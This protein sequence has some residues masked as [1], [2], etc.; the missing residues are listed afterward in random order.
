MTVIIEKTEVLTRL[1][2]FNAWVKTNCEGRE[3]GEA[4]TYLNRFFQCFGYDDVMGAGGTFENAQKASSKKGNTG[5]LD[6]LFPKVAII[7]MKQ[8]GT[9]LTHHYNQLLTYWTRCT[10]KPRVGILCNFDEFWIYDFNVQVDDPVQILTLDQLSQHPEALLFMLG[11]EP[12]FHQNMVDITEDASAEIS[13]LY[14]SILKRRKKHDATEEDV[15]RF[16]LQCVLCLFAEDIGL[17]PDNLFTNLLKDCLKSPANTYNVLSGLFTQMNTR[18]EATGGRFKGVKYFNGGLFETITPIE[19]E[20][21]ELNILY[22]LGYDYD[23]SKVRPS[24]F[25]TIFEKAIGHVQGSH[26]TSEIDIYKIVNPTIVQYWDERIEKAG[27]NIKKLNQ[28]LKDIRQYKVLDPAC[29]SGNFLY[30]AYQE[31]KRIEKQL[32]LLIN[33]NAKTARD[34]QQAQMSYVTPLQFYGFEIK[35]FAVELARLTLEIGRKIAV[36]KFN[37]P[38]DVLPL[39]DLKKNIVCADALF[40]EWP[41]T[42]VIIGNPPFSGRSKLRKDFGDEYVDKIFEKHGGDINKSADYC[43]YWFRLAQAHHAKRIG[44]VATNSIKQN[45][46]REASL[47]HITVNGGIIFNAISSLIWTGDAKVHHSIVN[48]TK[49]KN[50]KGKKFLDQEEVDLINPDLTTGTDVT[51]ARLLTTNNN[52]CFQGVIP[53]PLERFEVNIELANQWIVE[54]SK[55]QDILKFLVSADDL[56]DKVDFKPPKMIIDFND[57][58]IEEA[59]LYPF[60]FEYLKNNLINEEGYDSK[61][62]TYHQEKWWIH[63]RNRNKMRKAISSL[64]KYIAI[65]GTSKWSMPVFLTH[66]FLCYVNSSFVVASDDFYLL[67]MITSAFHQHWVKAQCSTLKADTRYT[68]TTCFD[69]FPFLWDTPE[70]KKDTVR[71][72]MEELEAY[73]MTE[74]KTRQWGITQLYN[75]FFNE[76]A[77][78]L[79][80]LHKK[81]DE[82]VCKVY[83]WEYDPDKN[84]NE[85]LFKLNQKLYRQEKEPLSERP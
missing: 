50:Y 80:K 20:A 61:N 8:R 32:M 84:Y 42:D 49:E 55:Y 11:E 57:R 3:R 73:R 36:N 10:P 37:L 83:G 29:G 34:A 51:K 71:R 26:F 16:V 79:H 40:N 44:L 13:N 24:I 28:C 70:K 25:G 33:E 15:Q 9:N 53:T 64:S 46:S 23:W 21:D 12:R 78:Q 38:E 65:P 35:P 7:E 75:A 63:W 82:T 67:G 6:C 18:K 2:G 43:V 85:D 17:L 81:L 19:L 30:I 27:T 60:A 72:V 31:L 22:H 69:T 5:F 14:Q 76:P 56:A 41:K 66:D 1:E 58:T 45:V 59:S 52:I 39:D 74:M 4:Q 68:N 77:S 47:D 48:W 62:P 54:D